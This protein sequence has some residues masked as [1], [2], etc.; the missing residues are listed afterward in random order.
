MAS[1][2]DTRSALRTSSLTYLFC[3]HRGLVAATAFVVEMY[4]VVQHTALQGRR[5]THWTLSSTMDNA[6]FSIAGMPFSPQAILST[7]LMLA[8]AYAVYLE[9][10]GRQM[11]IQQEFKSAQKLQRVLIPQS[12]PSLEGYAV[13]SAY[14]PAQQVG[15]DFFQLIQQEGGSAVLVVGDVRGKG[16]KAAMAVSLIVGAV[17]TLVESTD[18]PGRILAGLNRRLHG[19][20]TNGFATCLVLKFDRDGNCVLANAGHLAPSLNREEL[21]MPGALPLGLDPEAM[22][23]E[24]AFRLSV[25]DRLTFYTDGL[26]EARNS[27]GELF[28]FERLHAL[29]ATMPDAKQATEAAVDFGQDDDI[30]VLTLTRLAVGT[31][32]TTSLLAPELA[33]APA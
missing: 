7:L 33:I 17:R 13:T 23:E 30:T 20:L 27:T 32:S 1:T 22:Y 26:L 11:A 3:Q 10:R 4:D 9:Q 19:R 29:I 8:I 12:L 18:D 14:Q 2:E 16:L 5:F 21:T 31:T 25:G 28:G 24:T 6:L 15:G